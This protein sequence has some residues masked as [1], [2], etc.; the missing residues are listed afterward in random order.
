MYLCT[1][2]KHLSLLSIHHLNIFALYKFTT[3]GMKYTSSPPAC[4]AASQCL[5]NAVFRGRMICKKDSLPQ[6]RLRIQDDVL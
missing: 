2:F 6:K 1:L 5:L 3:V 4:L